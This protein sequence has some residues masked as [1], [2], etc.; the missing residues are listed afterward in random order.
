MQEELLENE[1]K[2]EVTNFKDAI[3]TG[4]ILKNIKNVTKAII[5]SK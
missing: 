3:F 2:D 1:L 4:A 5:P